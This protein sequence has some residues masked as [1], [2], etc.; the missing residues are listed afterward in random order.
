MSSSSTTTKSSK[1]RVFNLE[2]NFPKTIEELIS[3]LEKR[4]L[5][6]PPRLT[7]YEIARIV[8]ARAKQLAMGAK[9]MIDISN[10][11]T[12]DPVII[13]LEELKQGKLPLI[14]SR[15]LPTGRRIEIKVQDLQ[16][17]EREYDFGIPY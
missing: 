16:K 15:R 7:K 2:E 11:G 6:F 14:I 9:P 12:Y 5:P 1:V 13:A 10:L 3:A 17:L 4:S 8:A